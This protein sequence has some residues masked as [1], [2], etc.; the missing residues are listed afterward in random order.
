MFFSISGV[1][2]PPRVSIPSVSGVTSSKSTSVTSPARTAA[3]MDAP[4]ATAS[5]GFTSRRASFLKKSATFFPTS[6]I[7]VWPPTRITSLISETF[8]PA[9]FS[10]VSTGPIVRS[11]RSS[12]RD[13]S[14]ERV[15]LT[16]RC[17][18][19]LAS[20]VIYGRLTSVC[21]EEDSSILAFSAASFRR[22]RASGSLCRSMPLVFLNSSAR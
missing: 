10:A 18:G 11:T 13:S 22:C 12:T 14:L 17:F 21:C 2:T 8:R 1:A 3:W 16:T 7:R 4:M 15:S 19:P 20:A 6:G 9:S 5:S